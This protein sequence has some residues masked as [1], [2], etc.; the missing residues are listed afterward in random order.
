MNAIEIKN[1]SKS[2][3]NIQALN[4]IDLEVPEGSIYGLIGPNGC[5]KT[6][7]IKTLVGTLKPDTGEIKVLGVNPLAGRWKI[8][9][10]IGYM[11]QSPAIYDDLSARDV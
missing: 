9:K 1:L 5:G 8:R 4:G 10:H 11:P 6:T 7:L 3:G 2:Y